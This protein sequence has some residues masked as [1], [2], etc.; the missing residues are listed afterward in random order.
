MEVLL[1]KTKITKSIFNQMQYARPKEVH[2]YN[3]LG[4]CLVSDEKFILLYDEKTKTPFKYQWFTNLMKWKKKDEDG[5]TQIYPY[6]VSITRISS[7]NIVFKEESQAE[8]VYN[9]LKRM[10]DKSSE[11]GQIFL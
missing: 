6:V 5:E 9:E 1:R 11:L 2:Q 8:E 4:W 7:S 3:V 10:I